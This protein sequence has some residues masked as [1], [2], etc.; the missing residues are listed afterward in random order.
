MRYKKNLKRYICHITYFI[1]KLLY[2][3]KKGIT[4]PNIIININPKISY[5]KLTNQT[6]N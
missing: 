3:P 5:L 4:Y 2:H 1:S 6:T